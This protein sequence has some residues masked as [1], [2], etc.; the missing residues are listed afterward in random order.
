MFKVDDEYVDDDDDVEEDTD[1]GR[2]SKASL[3]Y[4]SPF[5]QETWEQKR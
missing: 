4:I 3:K 1:G 5:L 2:L